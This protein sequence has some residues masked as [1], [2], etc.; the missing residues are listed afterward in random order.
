M[1]PALSSVLWVQHKPDRFDTWSTGIVMMQMALPPLRNPRGLALFKSEYEK[2]DYDL[3]AWRQSCRW[4]TKKDTAALDADNGAGKSNATAVMWLEHALGSVNF[5]KPEHCLSEHGWTQV[6]KH[7]VSIC[8]QF[9]CS[10]SHAGH[11]TY[12]TCEAAA[13]EVRQLWALQTVTKPQV[14]ALSLQVGL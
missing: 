1:A 5:S 9:L 12:P 10:T 8:H 7:M 11:S 13:A 14:T 6:R 2:C 3:E 4:V